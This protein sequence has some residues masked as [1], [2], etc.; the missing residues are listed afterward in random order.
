L[1]HGAENDLGE[2]GRDAELDGDENGD[3]GKTN[4]KSGEQPDL[5]HGVPPYPIPASEHKKNLHHLQ[6]IDA[7]VI[8]PNLLDGYGEL[9]RLLVISNTTLRSESRQET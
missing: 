4:P 3:E 7:G 1:S 6:H 5:R 2:S 9:L 8:S